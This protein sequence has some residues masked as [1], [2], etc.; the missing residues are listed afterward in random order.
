MKFLVILLA[1]ILTTC[2]VS[3][4]KMNYSEIAKE[5][6]ALQDADLK[7][8]SELLRKG[9]MNDGYNPE[10]EKMHNLNADG[11]DKII[12]KNRLSDN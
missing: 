7:L 4:N 6:I 5:I 10:M 1:V 3:N 9:Q 11:L 12:D 8:R 2:S